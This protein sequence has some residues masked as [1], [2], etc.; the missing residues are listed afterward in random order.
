[1][2]IDKMDYVVRYLEDIFHV[3][4]ILRCQNLEGAVEVTKTAQCTLVVVEC[5]DIGQLV[6]R[7]RLLPPV[8]RFE[9]EGRGERTEREE[10]GEERRI[11][12]R[13]RIRGR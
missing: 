12:G 6:H 10:R 2:I 8:C 7:R 5:D 4:K 11:D 3:K 1:M 13:N 9:G